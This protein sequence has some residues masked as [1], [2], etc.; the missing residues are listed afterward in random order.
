MWAVEF[1]NR[2]EAYIL[3]A[4]GALVFII[5]FYRCWREVLEEHQKSYFWWDTQHQLNTDTET[6]K[7]YVYNEVDFSDLELFIRKDDKGK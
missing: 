5:I 4:V 7:D 1:L 2:Y 3:Y 6:D